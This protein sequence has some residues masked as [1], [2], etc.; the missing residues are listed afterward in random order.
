METNT[1]VFEG[2][3]R[4]KGRHAFQGFDG[5]DGWLRMRIPACIEEL[6]KLVRELA[7]F[8]KET[9]GVV[10]AGLLCRLSLAL[11]FDRLSETFCSLGEE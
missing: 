5:H 1:S 2:E 8:F 7:E 9:Q 6:Q 3:G 10:C 4:G 11:P